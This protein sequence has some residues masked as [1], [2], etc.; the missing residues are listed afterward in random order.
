MAPYSP[1]PWL[2]YGRGPRFRLMLLASCLLAFTFAC[3]GFVQRV[4]T[5]ASGSHGERAAE[6]T[7][8]TPA[9]HTPALKPHRHNLRR[10]IIAAQRAR[11]TPADRADEEISRL[12]DDTVARLAPSIGM[13]PVATWCLVTTSVPE[14]EICQKKPPSR[15]VKIDPAVPAK[16]LDVDITINSPFTC[17]LPGPPPA[18][19]LE[20]AIAWLD[21]VEEAAARAKAQGKLLFV[22]HLSGNF[23]IPGYT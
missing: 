15:I 1:R 6:A 7:E 12:I 11:E 19:T 22:M 16:R 3:L 20:T 18:R 10:E 14:K 21:S 4:P 13:G 23:A 8:I 17:G 2:R 9:T 5:P